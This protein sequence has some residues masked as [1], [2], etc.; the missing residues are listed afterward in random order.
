VRVHQVLRDHEAEHRVAQKLEALVVGIATARFVGV[1]RV[2][3]RL[4][5]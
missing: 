2:R 5:E 4:L 1:R 3:E